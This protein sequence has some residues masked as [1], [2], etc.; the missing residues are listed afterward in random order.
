V[1]LLGEDEAKPVR[2]M[3]ARKHPFQQGFAV[4]LLHRVKRYKTLH[5]ELTLDP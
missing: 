1:R 2:R 5:Y 3:L 4:P